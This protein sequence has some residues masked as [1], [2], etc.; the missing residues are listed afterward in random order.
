M[1]HGAWPAAYASHA[2]YSRHQWPPYFVGRCSDWLGACVRASLC[3]YVIEEPFEDKAICRVKRRGED[4]QLRIFTVDDVKKAGLLGKQ[5]PWTQYPKRMLQMR[6]RSW[7]LRDVFPDVL[8]GVQ[9]AEEVM[10]IEPEKK[11]LNPRPKRQNAAEIAQ[12]AVTAELDGHDLDETAK[13]ALL[14]K[15]EA[16][17][18]T[19]I[20][21][22]QQTWEAIGQEKRKA[23]GV[24]LQALKERAAGAGHG[25]Q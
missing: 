13:V 8:R 6:A 20:D 21:A 18:D 1:R 22:L 12:Q 5:G 10:D 24:H 3:E 4:E 14:A 15:L 9:I 17:V 2:E 19:G 25:A 11:D 7:A 16:V 23:M